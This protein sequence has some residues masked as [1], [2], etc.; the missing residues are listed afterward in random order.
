MASGDEIVMFKDGVTEG[1]LREAE[2]FGKERL[3][4][5]LNAD[6]RNSSVR[7]IN[8]IDEEPPELQGE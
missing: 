3:D 1:K 5:V 2:F 4:N 7:L 8:I 6:K